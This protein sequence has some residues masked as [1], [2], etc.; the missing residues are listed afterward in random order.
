MKGTTAIARGQFGKG[1]VI[2]FSP[3]PEVTRGLEHF[4]QLAIRDARP[5]R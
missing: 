1:R 2:C 5:K 4:I 3:H